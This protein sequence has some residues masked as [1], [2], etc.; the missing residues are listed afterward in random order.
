MK[1]LHCQKEMRLLYTA[2]KGDE[3]IRRVFKCYECELLKEDL[4]P[5]QE[6]RHDKIH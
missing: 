1:C 4:K 5:T 3:I 2:Y 6:T